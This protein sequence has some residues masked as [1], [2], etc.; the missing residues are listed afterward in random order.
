MISTILL[1]TD[2]PA[3]ACIQLRGKSVNPDLHAVVISGYRDDNNGNLKELYV[4]DD[5]I[6]PY[7]KVCPKYNDGDFSFWRNEWIT[8]NGYKDI[9]V[10]KLLIPIYPKIRLSFNNLYEVF[11]DIKDTGQNAELFLKEIKSYKN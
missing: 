1:D 2:L 8:K 5:Q 9:F 7:S 6:G 10:D 11:L 3:I 4:H